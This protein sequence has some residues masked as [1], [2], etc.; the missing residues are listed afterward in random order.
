MDAIRHTGN[1]AAHEGTLPPVGDDDIATVLL[2]FE[3]VDQIVHSAITLPLRIAHL[4][5]GKKRTLEA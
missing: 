3:V 4:N 5:E 2:L 1:Q